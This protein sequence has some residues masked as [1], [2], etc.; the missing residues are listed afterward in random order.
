MHVMQTL[1]GWEI[2]YLLWDLYP[3][4]VCLHTQPLQYTFSS[5]FL[6]LASTACEFGDIP[7]IQTLL[8]RCDVEGSVSH[9]EQAMAKG[10]VAQEPLILLGRMLC[11]TGALRTARSLLEQIVSTKFVCKQHYTPSTNYQVK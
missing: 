5:A 2:L 9:L 1:Q 6:V 11:W 10:T 7:R 3:L 8:E 4:H